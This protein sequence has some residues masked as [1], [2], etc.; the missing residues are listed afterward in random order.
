MM[1]R[2]ATASTNKSLPFLPILVDLRNKH[3]LVVGAGTVAAAKIESLL[4]CGARIEVVSPGA[5]RAISD[6]ASAGTITWRRRRFAP[7]DVRGKFLVIAATGSVRTNRAIF[8]ASAAHGVLCNSV[9]DPQRC[10][11]FFPALVRRGPLQIAIS[12]GGC[13]PS[14]AARMR[15]DL[16]VQFGPE[17]GRWVEHLG[18]LRSAILAQ[19]TTPLARRRRLEQIA[20]PQ[21]FR[22][23]LR[24]GARRAGAT[25]GNKTR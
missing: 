3:C 23:F 21:A 25:A 24:A 15:R 6:R 2:R 16:E 9:D 1:T 12:T 8:R 4:H 11:F 5:V 7:E 19:Q 20:T 22:A 14:L 17:W 18:K 13:S 10:N